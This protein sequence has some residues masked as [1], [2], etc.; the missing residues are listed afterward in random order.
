MA[1]VYG[2][3]TCVCFV[4][5]REKLQQSSVLNGSGCDGAAELRAKGG[6]SCVSVSGDN[7]SIVGWP[8]GNEQGGYVPTVGRW[9]CEWPS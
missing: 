1:C 4:A 2:F 6:P 8:N 3:R 5:E 9:G 7:G